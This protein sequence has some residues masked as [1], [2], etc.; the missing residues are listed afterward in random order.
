MDKPEVG[1]PESFSISVQN[2][3]EIG[4]YLDETTL[5]EATDSSRPKRVATTPPVSQTP[6]QSSQTAEL[7]SIQSTRVPQQSVE[8]TTRLRRKP[9]RQINMSPE[10]VQKFEEIITHIQDFGPQPDA[11]ASEIWE[12]IVNAHHESLSQLRLGSVRPRG[13]WGSPTANAF[14]YALSKAFA[15][16]I[17]NCHK[18]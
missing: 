13:A 5:A 9:R 6:T 4:D 1:L 18:D 2:P 15:N 3:V 11:A 16:A 8:A 7:E 17:V 12:A 10:T 14:K